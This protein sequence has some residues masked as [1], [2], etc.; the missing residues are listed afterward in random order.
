MRRSLFSEE[1]I[2]GMIKNQEA[3]IPTAEVCRKHGLGT[4][5]FC[6]YK[7]KFGGM[8]ESESI[9]RLSLFLKK[10][11]EGDSELR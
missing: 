10:A 9:R 7:A 2:I 1:Q 8:D 6:R 5:S 4:A 11:R 3:G